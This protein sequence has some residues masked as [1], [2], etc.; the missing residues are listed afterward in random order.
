LH[1]LFGERWIA[2]DQGNGGDELATVDSPEPGRLFA[3]GARLAGYLRHI[4][5]TLGG[6]SGLTEIFSITGESRF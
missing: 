6:V 2:A 4:R 5:R 3:T 1:R